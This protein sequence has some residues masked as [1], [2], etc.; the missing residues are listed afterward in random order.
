MSS[1][2]GE[3]PDRRS[4]L[5][6]LEARTVARWVG[7]HLLGVQIDKGRI[8][9]GGL[10]R[11]ERRLTVA[12][13]VA[14][15]SIILLILFP[16]LVPSSHTI[17]LYTQNQGGMETVDTS[18]S[19]LLL[20][21]LGFFVGLLVYAATE[22]PGPVRVITAIGFAFVSA[23][24]AN[25]IGNYWGGVLPVL[26]FAS[27]LLVP[28]AL[29]IS[30]TEN[31]KIAR[32]AGE[33]WSRAIGLSR[34]VAVICVAVFFL[35]CT[36]IYVTGLHSASFQAEPGSSL[37]ADV[38][39]P[40]QETLSNFYG[41]MVILFVVSSLAV[42]R[43]SYG[44]GQVVRGVARRAPRRWARWGLVALIAAEVFFVLRRYRGD[45][46][47]SL[48][49]YPQIALACGLGVAMF[50][51][52]TLGARDLFGTP[53]REVETERVILFGA[54]AYSV[55]LVVVGVLVSAS[56][57][58]AALFPR[59]GGSSI[60]NPFGWLATY[61]QDP[62]F[63]LG[64]AAVLFA[65]LLVAGM[66]R[67]NGG[68][69]LEKRQA[70]FGLALIAGWAL[71]TYVISF[72]APLG[73]YSVLLCD[74]T[75]IVTAVVAVD[76]VRHWDH[77]SANRIGT[78]AAVVVLSWL[79]STDGGFLSIV[80]GWIGLHSNVPLAFG[81][82]LTIVGA[83]EFAG[84]NSRR[85]PRRV[86]PVIWLSYIGISLLFRLSFQLTQGSNDLQ[87]EYLLDTTAGYL[88][89][90]PPF[91]AWLVLTG[92]FEEHLSPKE[93]DSQPAQSKPVPFDPPST[94]EAT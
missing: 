55:G 48:S 49:R 82:L 8:R 15:G 78:L 12:A 52:M 77:L 22:C 9:F 64:A 41:A 60:P 4:S 94:A 93:A 21:G 32:R 89:M 58:L 46:W 80:G 53:R 62:G 33:R 73:L 76:L 18:G 65:V 42:V 63:Q 83:S 79:V 67:A 1:L 81:A 10:N 40:V 71:W 29:F 30:A 91:A 90:A 16:N 88:L 59:R 14:V 57:V 7:R 47:S 37:V 25:F 26:I 68:V 20:V 66:R 51:W 34:W 5:E 92:W 70:G 43:F 19:A 35:G 61:A 3:A 6:Q 28:L 54:G 38:A 23:Q 13:L 69:S 2:E 39:V 75:L 27:Y 74:L 85:F 17:E 72:V 44:I 11:L 24:I 86:R 84:G 31:S 87:Q 36:V 56:W 50:V 45:G